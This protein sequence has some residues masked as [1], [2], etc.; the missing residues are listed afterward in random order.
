MND[1]ESFL[2]SKERL[3]GD[4]GVDADGLP[5][6]LFD[7]QRDLV[8]WACRRGRAALF[9]STGLGKTAMQLAWAQQMHRR[10]GVR[11]LILAPLAVSAQTVAEAA[12]FGIDGV[13]LH[14][15]SSAPIV[16]T[17]YEKLGRVDASQFGAV[18][19]DES[20][21]L[22]A[23]DGKTRT[24]LIETFAA[25]PY[26]LACTATPSPNDFTELGN[27]AEFLGVMTRTEMLATYFVHDGGDTQ[28]WRLKGHAEDAFW[29]WVASWGAFVRSPSDLGYSAGG[30]DLP[31]LS[32]EHH[33]VAASHETAAAVGTLFLM[34]AKSLQE[35]RAARRASLEERVRLA[36]EMA[37]ANDEQW[38]LWCDLN[39]EGDALTKAVRGAVQVKGADS[40]EHKERAMLDFAAGKLR[41]LVSKGSICGY[42]MNFQSCANMAFVGLSDSWETFF[43]SVRRC[44]R[45]GQRRSVAVHIITSELDG[46]VRSNVLRKQADFDRLSAEVAAHTSAFV[47]ANVRA[48]ARMSDTHRIGAFTVPAWL[49]SEEEVAA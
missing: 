20:S 3:H 18:V 10:A 43:Q 25:T 42:G 6:Q 17:N 12:R 41:V 36:A 29:R 48:A 23:F 32:I 26:R 9:C 1:Y 24:E 2:R 34:E 27:H 28:T 14:D 15:A 30:Y 38:L 22:K 5:P 13:A 7:F 46:A 8:T 16:V 49:V 31:P 33:T 37:N 19:L 4:A 45:Y 44:W 35:R 40:A 11:V 21:I 39:D 47:Q